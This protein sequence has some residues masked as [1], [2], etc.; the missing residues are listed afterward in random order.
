MENQDYAI[1]HLGATLISAIGVTFRHG[2]AS[3]ASTL[4]YVPDD[5]ESGAANIVY[6]FV[7]W[8]SGRRDMRPGCVDRLRQLV[9]DLD[10]EGA[11]VEAAALERFKS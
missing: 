3:P 6:D 8:T 5:F 4:D 9:E 2:H 1:T 10:W 7:A 11:A